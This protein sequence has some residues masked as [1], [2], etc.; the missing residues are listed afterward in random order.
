VAYN[1]IKNTKKHNSKTYFPCPL[2][3]LIGCNELSQQAEFDLSSLNGLLLLI[4]DTIFPMLG[5][6]HGFLIIRNVC[7]SL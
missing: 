6:Q 3:L 5:G 7:S 4:K 2:I 1:T